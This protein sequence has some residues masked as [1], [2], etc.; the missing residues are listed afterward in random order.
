MQTGCRNMPSHFQRVKRSI[1]KPSAL[2]L[3]LIYA[4]R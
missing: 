1:G 3:Y 2:A 4:S